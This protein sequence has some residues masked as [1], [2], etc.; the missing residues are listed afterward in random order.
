M[1]GRDVEL[2]VREVGRSAL[3]IEPIED[4]GPVSIADT[5][6]LIDLAERLRVDLTGQLGVAIDVVPAART[7]L[8]DG[9]P[10]A[11]APAARDLVQRAVAA[12]TTTADSTARGGVRA[13]GASDGRIVDLPVT[14]DGPD[15]AA[16]ARAWGIT[17]DEVAERHAAQE[18]VVAFCGFAPGFA[19]VRG[20]A[21]LPEVPRLATPR[22]RVPPGA[23][24]LAGR[25]TGIYPTASPGGWQLIGHTDVSL[26]DLAAEPPALLRPGCRVRFVPQVRS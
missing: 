2:T 5:W 21:D 12:A 14:Y 20:D 10:A 8:V 15:L 18:H 1:A 4:T 9:L 25:F 13:S 11:A 23:V 22:T 16:V 19:Y 3:L 17:D 7:V 24:G 6:R 26:W